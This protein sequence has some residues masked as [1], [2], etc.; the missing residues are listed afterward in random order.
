MHSS[1]ILV[2]C[3][4]KPVEVAAPNASVATLLAQLGFGSNGIA[5]ERNHEV[6]PKAAWA[7]TILTVGDRLEVVGF[8]GG[9]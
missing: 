8:V 5:V 3:N 1:P 6:V 9:G 4:G 7:S 2:V